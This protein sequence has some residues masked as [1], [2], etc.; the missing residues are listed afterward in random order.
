MSG[1]DKKRAKAFSEV[2]ALGYTIVPIDINYATKSWTILEGKKFMPSFLSCKGVGEAAIDEI[3]ANRPY[4]DIDDLLW[5][6]DGKWKHSKFNKR[7]MQALIAIKAFGSMKCVG[8]D[9]IFESY[10]H[11]NE[12]VIANNT[13]VKK[14]TKKDPTRG[15]D[16]FKRILLETSGEGEWSRHEQ[17]QNSV[18]HLGS[19]NVSTLI[20]PEVIQRLDDKDINVIDDYNGVDLHWFLVMDVKEKLTKNKKPYLLL[21]VAGTSGQQFR[22]FCW[23]WDGKT[24]MP[25]YSLCVGELN[26][27]DYGFQ[28]SMRKIKVLKV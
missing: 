23:S 25:K 5:N 1:N 11:M 14:W 9:S 22:I 10:K 16:A 20:S 19:F 7:A 6:E 2:K 13:E 15:Q 12:V 26:K 17:V 3:L 18:A 21:T 24:E 27:N 4:S 8:K 28:T